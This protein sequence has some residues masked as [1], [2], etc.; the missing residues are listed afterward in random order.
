MAGFHLSIV[1]I[2][3][4]VNIVVDIVSHRADVDLKSNVELIISI[5]LGFVKCIKAV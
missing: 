1:Y 5:A 2:L 4:K 3:G